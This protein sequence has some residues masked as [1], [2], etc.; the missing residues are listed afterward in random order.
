MSSLEACIIQHESGGNPTAVNGQ[1]TGIA[2]WSPAA[3]AED[4]GTRF[5]SSP[6]GASYSQQELVL[7]EALAAGKSEQWRPY[8]GC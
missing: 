3:W 1:Y 8:D 2:Q 4:G 5:A 7:R 6:L